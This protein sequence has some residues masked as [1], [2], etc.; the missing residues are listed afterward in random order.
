M[1]G[2]TGSTAR[3]SPRMNTAARQSTDRSAL[4]A[5]RGQVLAWGLWDWGSAA[6]NAVI[7]TFVFSVYL[8]DQVGDD[9]PGD[10]EREQLARLLD[11]RG[12]AAHRA[13]GAGDRAAG[14]RGRAPQVRHRRLDRA[15]DRDDGRAVLR[16]GRLALPVARAAAARRRVDLL[17]AGVGVVQRGAD[18]GLDAGD[19]RAR[20]GLRLGDGLPGRDRAAARRLPGLRRRRRRRCSAS[21]PRT[22]STS[23]WSRW[24][25]PAWFLVFAVP[26]FL[27]VPEVAAAGRPAPG[28]SASWPPT[29]RSSPTCAASTARARTPS[30][31]SAR[32]RC[33]AT[34]SP[35]SSRSARCWPSPSTA[36]ARATC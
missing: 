13:D 27:V 4:A 6:Y 24:S 2:V 16:R 3:Y 31:S 14:R 23:G 1:D 29:R 21:R 19:D 20:L 8:T 11:R 17:R 32:A 30:T 10:V 12:R 35:R 22:G 9:L 25:R 26:M 36:S 33:S 28:G 18:A 7:L 5:G 15:D 34:G